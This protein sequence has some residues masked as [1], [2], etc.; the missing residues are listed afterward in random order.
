MERCFFSVHAPTTRPRQRTAEGLLA[1]RVR[2]RLVVVSRER[3]RRV[4]AARRPGA[5]ARRKLVVA[6]PAAAVSLAV[7]TQAA[8]AARA[9][10]VAGAAGSLLAARRE[11]AEAGARLAA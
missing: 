2:A 8:Q 3:A 1:A 11:W 5:V 7:L 6:E 10:P 4:A 9:A